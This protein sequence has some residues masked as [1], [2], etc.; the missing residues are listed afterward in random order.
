VSTKV[1][2]LPDAGTYVLLDVIEGRGDF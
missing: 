1:N 2:T